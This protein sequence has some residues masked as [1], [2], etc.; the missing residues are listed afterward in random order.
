MTMVI[1]V[2]PRLYC[3]LSVTENSLHNK[4]ACHLSAEVENI[5]S[6]SSRNEGT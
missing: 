4:D 1:A 5:I 6:K 3:S 2:Y